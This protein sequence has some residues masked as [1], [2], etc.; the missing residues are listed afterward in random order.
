[1]TLRTINRNLIVHNDLNIG[2]GT[3]VQNRGDQGA[4]TEQKIEL[5]FIFRSIAE[6]KALDEDKYTRVSLHAA[7]PVIGYYF[8][9]VALF[10]TMTWFYCLTAAW[11]LADG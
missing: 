3:E 9:P 10:L 5:D 8:D 1:M 6:I 2:Y 11:L 7:G 4:T